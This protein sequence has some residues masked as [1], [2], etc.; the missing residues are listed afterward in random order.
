MDKYEKMYL[1]K[2]VVGLAICIPLLV[3][4]LKA[5]PFGE[6]WTP[7]VIPLTFPVLGLAAALFEGWHKHD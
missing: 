5:E 2:L 6:L 1:I 7:I 3:L 4:V